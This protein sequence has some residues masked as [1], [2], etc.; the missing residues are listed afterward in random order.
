ML[1]KKVC[2]KA[3]NVQEM[4]HFPGLTQGSGRQELIGA[5]I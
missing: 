3:E 2:G 5:V 4:E 1:I